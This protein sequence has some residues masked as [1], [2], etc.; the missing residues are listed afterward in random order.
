MYVIIIICASEGAKTNQTAHKPSKHW[1][2][3]ECGE[4]ILDT[5]GTYF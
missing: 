3:S 1:T 5:R 4:E 2:V